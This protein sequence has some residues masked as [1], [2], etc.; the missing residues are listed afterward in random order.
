M[1][2][3]IYRSL[4]KMV[5]ESQVKQMKLLASLEEK[6]VAEVM[7][8]VYNWRKDEHR[9]LSKVTRDKNELGRMKREVNSVLVSKGVVERE[10][11]ERLYKDIKYNLEAAH[12]SVLKRLEEDKRKVSCTRSKLLIAASLMDF[13]D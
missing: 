4:E 1:F 12:A 9:R 5:R 2:S 6:E 8:W 10:K 13:N 7:K 11:K 3:Q